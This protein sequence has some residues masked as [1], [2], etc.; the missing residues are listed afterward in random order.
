MHW[1]WTVRIY[2]Y[3]YIYI[4]CIL[5]IKSLK[6]KFTYITFYKTINEIIISILRSV[7][8]TTVSVE[9]Q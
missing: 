7:R 6:S 4:Y 8:G 2:I 1:N 9:K 3:I 5:Y